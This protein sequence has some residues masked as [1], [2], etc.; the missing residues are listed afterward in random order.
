MEEARQVNISINDKYFSIDVSVKDWE[1]IE[2]I[3]SSFTEYLES[4]GPIKIKQTYVESLSDSMKIISKLISKK[5]Q[6]DR[7]KGETKQL[8]SVLRKKG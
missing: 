7:W 5:E 1:L 3:F 6:V 2:T 4:G 8:I